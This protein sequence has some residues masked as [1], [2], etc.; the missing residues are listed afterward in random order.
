MCRESLDTSWNDA[1][2][3]FFAAY[4]EL[5]PSSTCNA[6]A[7][8]VK[9]VREFQE[10]V[11]CLKAPQSTNQISLVSVI[12]LVIV[13]TKNYSLQSPSAISS[14]LDSF[15]F[16]SGRCSSSS[17]RAAVDAFCFPFLF[18]SGYCEA[19]W[20][21][22]WH[23]T[24]VEFWLWRWLGGGLGLEFWCQFWALVSDISFWSVSIREGLL[25]GFPPCGVMPRLGA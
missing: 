5:S 4:L 13:E 11:M 25:L 17:P 2:P 15:V 3:T 1:V 24:Y 12:V 19:S 22:V 14:S 16:F 7:L 18:F 6:D 21:N 10:P 9:F 20:P 8:S 23:L